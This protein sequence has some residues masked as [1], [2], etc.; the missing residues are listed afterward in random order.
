MTSKSFW[1]WILIAIVESSFC[2]LYPLYALRNQTINEGGQSLSSF[3]ESGAITY[4]LIILVVTCKIAF[5]QEKWNVSESDRGWVGGWVGGWMICLSFW[6]SGAITYTLIILVV[7]CKIAF[8]Q[9][10]WNVRLIHP[11]T[12]PPTPFILSSIHHPVIPPIDSSTS[13]EPF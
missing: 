3:W 9:E 4:T 5:R 8:R 6:E 7:T 2:S 11:P 12:H 13:L 10:K 1:G